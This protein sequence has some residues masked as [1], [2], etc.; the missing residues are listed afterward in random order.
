MLSADWES[1][2]VSRHQKRNSLKH[3]ANFIVMLADSLTLRLL[4]RELK[5]RKIKVNGSGV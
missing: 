2:P 3:L 4:A 1:W 5:H